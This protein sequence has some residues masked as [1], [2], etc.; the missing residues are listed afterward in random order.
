MPLTPRA[1]RVRARAGAAIALVAATIISTATVAL[2]T[3]SS[4]PPSFKTLT[5]W[6]G[7]ATKINTMPATTD[8]AVT[9]INP[10]TDASLSPQ[11]AGCWVN[12][13]NVAVPATAA[14][15]CAY[16]D[17]SAT[18]TILLTGDSQAGMWLPS[19]DAFGT[20]NAWKIVYLAMRECA[21]WGDP[22]KPNF[23]LFKN[24]TVA[25]CNQRN[26]NVVNWAIAQKPTAIL[27]SGRGYPTGYNIDLNPPV[28][29]LETEMTKALTSMKSVTGSKVIILGPIP[30]Y[31]SVSTGFSPTAC[32]DFAKPFTACHL[33]P[34]RLM[35]A[36]EVI[37]ERYEVSHNHAVVANLE[38][39]LCTTTLC[40]IVVK[41]SAGDVHVVYADGAHIDVKFGQ[42]IYRA[43]GT[44]LQ[45][46]LPV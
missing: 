46:L 38:P 5:I 14:T 4:P 1:P 42:W 13:N 30:R 11:R 23:I 45:P 2:A 8:P 34:T 31:T 40:T 7:V 44:I 41:D 6:V 28:A 20:A 24:V 39:L 36:N 19:L 9:S 12:G 16:G 29:T 22:N 43:V 10:L 25:N 35:P 3:T 17:L 37:A 18:R 33:S 27:L 15:Q 21:P 26:T 32:L